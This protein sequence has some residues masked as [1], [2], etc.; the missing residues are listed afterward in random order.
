[1]HGKASWKGQSLSFAAALCKIYCLSVNQEQGHVNR[2]YTSHTSSTI[3]NCSTMNVTGSYNYVV[4]NYEYCRN[5]ICQ[6]VRFFKK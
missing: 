6:N 3:L 4:F 2:S 5:R 1:M